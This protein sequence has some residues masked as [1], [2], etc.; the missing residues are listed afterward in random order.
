MLMDPCCLRVEGRDEN[1]T[2]NLL[3]TME[4]LRATVAHVGLLG[5]ALVAALYRMQAAH[6]VR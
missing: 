6:L 2:A 4:I 1:G 5:L 3:A